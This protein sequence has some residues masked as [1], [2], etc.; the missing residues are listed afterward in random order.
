MLLIQNYLNGQ[1][2]PPLAGRYLSNVE[3]ATGQVYG[4]IPD[5]GPEDVAAAVAAAEA[6]LPAWRARPA[7]TARTTARPWP[8]PA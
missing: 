2:V 6:A 5:S 8:W 3:P 1:L 4:Q 7:P